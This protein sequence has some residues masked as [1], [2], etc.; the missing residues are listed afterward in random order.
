MD[1]GGAGRGASNGG[2]EVRE[3]GGSSATSEERG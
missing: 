3:E 1:L 2:E